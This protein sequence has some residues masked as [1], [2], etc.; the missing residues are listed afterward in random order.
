[1]CTAITFTTRDHYF[2][3][4]LD[5]EYSYGEGVVITPRQYPLTF[6]RLEPMET[7]YAIIGMAAVEQG[8]PLYFD[9]TNERGLSMA[10]LNFPD[11]ACFSPEKPGADNVA[12]F[13]FILWILGQ[14]GTV[15][16][17]TARLATLHLADMP[18]SDQL[19]VSPLHWMIAD[20]TRAITIEAMADGL[21]IYPNRVGVLTNNPPFPMQMNRLADY[22]AL[23]PEQPAN[24]L[25]DGVDLP[26]YS[27][28]MGAIGLPGDLSSPSRFVRAAFIKA[29][30]R[31][32]ETEAESVGQ[33]FHI[34]AGVAQSRGCNRT[35]EGD[36]ITRYTSCCNMDR[37]V[38]YYT[39]YQNHRITAVD[40][41]REDLDA[42]QLIAYPLQTEEQIYRQN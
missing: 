35:P 33:F 29:H 26:L 42:T 11:N 30:S 12:P 13:E 17:T 25:T 39:T 24:R 2:G 18:F 16:E 40:M 34:L 3:R 37:G 10:G 23:S 5:L 19:P 32:D 9:A 41:H 8:Y 20:Q 31:C 15:E 38:Y 27:K 7:H 14:C 4:N 28:G 6:R 36:E 21:H 1:M 22:Q